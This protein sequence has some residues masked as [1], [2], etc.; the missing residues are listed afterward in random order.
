MALLAATLAAGSATAQSRAVQTAEAVAKL[1]VGKST[2]K[3][4]LELLGKADRV[5]R[6]E[7]KG[8]DEWGYRVYERGQ[9]GTLWISMSADG[10]VR[11]VNN[12]NESAL[13]RP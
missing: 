3:E 8:L 5:T 2:S 10:V 13:S 7:R 1:Q 9:S 11:E 6:N 4:V 12:I